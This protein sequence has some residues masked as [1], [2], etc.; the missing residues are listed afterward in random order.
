LIIE[1][2]GS[3]LVLMDPDPG[4]PKTYRSGTGSATLLKSVIWN[5]LDPFICSV[6]PV[7][8]PRNNGHSP[9]ESTGAGGLSAK[10]QAVHRSTPKNLSK[11]DQQMS[12]VVLPVLILM[13]VVYLDCGN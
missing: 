12:S 13:A 4:G 8:T 10:A 11:R 5:A 2:S 1:G 6:D 3:V 9:E 7:A